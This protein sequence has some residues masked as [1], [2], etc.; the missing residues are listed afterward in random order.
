[1]ATTRKRDEPVTAGEFDDK[2]AEAHGP[3]TSVRLAY[4]DGMNKRMRRLEVALALVSSAVL[5]LA[6]VFLSR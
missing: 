5:L 3:M 6:I 1:M 2:I 4:G